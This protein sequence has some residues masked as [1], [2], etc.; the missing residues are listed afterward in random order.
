MHEGDDTPRKLLVVYF[1]L[2]WLSS[3]QED[4]MNILLLLVPPPPIYRS[5][6]CCVSRW[7][8]NKAETCPVVVWYGG[9]TGTTLSGLLVV[10]VRLD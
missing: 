8:Q 6:F 5:V 4:A 10:F 9:T 2:G 7:N 3:L 1:V